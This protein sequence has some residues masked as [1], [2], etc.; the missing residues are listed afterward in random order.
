M[1]PPVKTKS[2]ELHAILGDEQIERYA[3]EF[4]QELVP[5]ALISE[6]VFKNLPDPASQRLADEH[7]KDLKTHLEKNQEG[8]VVTIARGKA[9]S[10]QTEWINQ[11]SE[12]ENETAHLKSELLQSMNKMKTSGVILAMRRLVGKAAKPSLETLISIWREGEMRKPEGS[13]RFKEMGMKEIPEDELKEMEDKVRRY[14]ELTVQQKHLMRIIDLMDRYLTTCPEGSDCIGEPQ[15]AHEAFDAVMTKR[16]FSSNDPDARDLLFLEY[17]QGIVLREQQVQ[18]FRDMVA[19]PNAA[20]QLRMGDG[21]SK[22]LLPIL[23]K[24]KANGSNLVMLMLPEELMRPIAATSIKPTG[25][26][27]AR[28]CIGST[29][30]AIPI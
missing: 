4:Q 5:A 7:L 25:S 26:F 17:T 1:Q 18:I 24:R 23:A 14:L 12:L 8:K 15:L 19:D 16:H 13:S 28:R 2:D 29:L 3:R 9:E 11:K 10:L 27:L 30:I 20:R 6:A 21:K 22:V